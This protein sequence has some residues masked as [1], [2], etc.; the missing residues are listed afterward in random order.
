MMR[1]P[2]CLVHGLFWLFVLLGVTTHA[3]ASQVDV[4]TQGVS[5][6]LLKNV[7]AYLSINTY[8]NSPNLNESLVER[9]NARAPQEIKNAL[10]PF[11]YYQPAVKSDLEKTQ[12][13]G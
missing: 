10:Q 9:L 13:V 3:M 6:N 8:R 1:K 11:G 4:Q 12:T 5:G 7:L 2:A